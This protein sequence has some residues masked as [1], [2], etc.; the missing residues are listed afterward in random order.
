MPEWPL[1]C[2]RARALSY[3]LPATPFLAATT[4]LDHGGTSG[5]RPLNVERG[6]RG[7]EPSEGDL[8]HHTSQG[9]FWFRQR[10]S[11][12]DQS[13]FPPLR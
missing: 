11:D 8:E 2:I 4:T 5:R 9:R 3:S 12:D 13:M 1:N 7:H 10:Y 6:H